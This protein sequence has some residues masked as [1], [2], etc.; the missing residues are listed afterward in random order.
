[1]VAK[2]IGDDGMDSLD[3]NIGL[4]QERAILQSWSKRKAQSSSPVVPNRNKK[5]FKQRLRRI[6]RQNR[7]RQ[8]VRRIKG[9]GHRNKRRRRDARSPNKFNG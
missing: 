1:M 2:V 7:Y 3:K 8:K 9:K 5:K 4:A 6:W